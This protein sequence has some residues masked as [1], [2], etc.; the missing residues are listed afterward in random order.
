M[1]D[2]R[3]MLRGSL[4]NLA[5]LALRIALSPLMLFLPRV[6]AQELFG[7]FVV[8]RSLVG[9]CQEAL[10]PGLGQGLAWRLPRREQGCEFRN[11]AVWGVVSLALL[12]GL[13][14]A[15]LLLVAF[16]GFREMLPTVLRDAPGWFVGICLASLPGMLVLRTACGAMDGIR[17]PAYRAFLAQS[18]AVGLVPVLALGFFLVGVPEALAWSLF[19]ASWLCALVVVWRLRREFPLG[20]DAVALVPE[21]ELLSY[22]AQLSLG[23]GVQA[24]LRGLDLWLVAWLLGSSE[25]AVYGVMLMLA[26]GIR[27]VARSY[28]PMIVPVVSG[29]SSPGRE[30]RLPTVL[31]YVQHVIAS[32][33]LVVAVFLVCFQRELLA[34]SGPQYAAYP[35]VFVMLVATSLVA[36]F[37]GVS[38][39]VLLGLGRSADVLKARLA[40]LGLAVGVGM[41]LVPRHGLAGAAGMSLA[42]G[43]AHAATLLVLQSRILG[44]WPDGGRGFCVSMALLAGFA[45]SAFVSAPLLAQADLAFRA[46]LFLALVAGLGLPAYLARRSFLP[47]A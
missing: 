29:A 32:V 13:A 24:L 10:G 44:R 17:R 18:L 36:G 47:P 3:F 5:G 8:L 40:M 23:N 19:G 35:Q 1:S 4:I 31:A 27:V 25:A 9:A 12:C 28:E 43:M 22:V 6:F 20:T 45:L 34:I 33:Q 30:G 16:L 37:H 11:G 38:A 46:G 7:L 42:V 14:G 26:N 21:R 41:V 39:Q 2:S 15:V